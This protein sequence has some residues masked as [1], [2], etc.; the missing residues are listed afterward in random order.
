MNINDISTQ[1]LYTT[2]PIYTLMSDGRQSS[3]TG[4]IFSV[5]EENNKSI[6]LLITNYHVLNTAIAGFFEMHI[7][8]KI[9]HLSKVLGCNSIKTSLMEISWVS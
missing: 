3:G 5:L 4:F 1:L 6:P 9:S 2:V 8:K 7:S